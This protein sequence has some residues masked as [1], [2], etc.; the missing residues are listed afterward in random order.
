MVKW[1]RVSVMLKNF[2]ETVFIILKYMVLFTSDNM[3]FLW[4]VMNRSFWFVVSISTNP[5][6]YQEE[7]YVF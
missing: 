2:I 5:K 6:L 4:C 3:H 7:D 1:L